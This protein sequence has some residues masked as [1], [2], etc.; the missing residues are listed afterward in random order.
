MPIR[1]EINRKLGKIRQLLE[2]CQAILEDF[3]NPPLTA[4]HEITEL[5][6]QIKEVQ[7]KIDRALHIWEAHGYREPQF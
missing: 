1:E 3:D 2:E 6:V 7:P 5:L 4:Y